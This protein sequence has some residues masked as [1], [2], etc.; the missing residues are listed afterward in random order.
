MIKSS[1]FKQFECSY[2]HFGKTKYT[3]ILICCIT[4]QGWLIFSWQLPLDKYNF[5]KLANGKFFSSLYMF[6]FF[7]IP[8]YQD[9]L[10]ATFAPSETKLFKKHAFYN[11]RT[12]GI[13][14][15]KWRNTLVDDD[16]I[17]T[18]L[19]LNCTLVTQFTDLIWFC[20]ASLK[21]CQSCLIA[22]AS[23]STQPYALAS[24]KKTLKTSHI[25]TV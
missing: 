16:I 24:Y 2:T 14:V 9:T 20:T 11:F 22:F 25:G 12:W 5:H 10:Y 6:L 17:M 18:Y 3:K 1:A 15:D 21:T 8:H 23:G 4:V 19:S 13:I 7:F